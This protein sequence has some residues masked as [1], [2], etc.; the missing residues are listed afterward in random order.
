MNLCLN[1]LLILCIIILAIFT[2]VCIISFIENRRLSVTGYYIE[3]EHIPEEFNGFKIVHITDMHNTSFGKDN[4]KLINKIKQQSPDIIVV[5]GDML[6]GHAG[7]DVKFAADTLNSLCDVAPVYF[8]MGNHEL[9]ISRYT[10]YYGDMWERF[11]R[12][13]SDDVKLLFDSMETVTRGDFHINLYGVTLTPKLY[14]RL[15]KVS[16]PPTV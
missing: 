8:S 16:M 13:L 14:T 11:L 7:A 3:D 15:K 5:T 4:I 6:V 1:I 10:E 12:Y 9:R 2:I